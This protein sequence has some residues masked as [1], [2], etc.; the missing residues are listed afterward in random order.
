M[1]YLVSTVLAF[2][3]SMIVNFGLSVL[4]VFSERMKRA[5]WKELTAFCIIGFVGLGLTAFI[6]WFCTD[7]FGLH[8]Q[9]QS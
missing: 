2:T 4:W 5:L 1:H 7:I 9:F 6:V 8:Y 3:I